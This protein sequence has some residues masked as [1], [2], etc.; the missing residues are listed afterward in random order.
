[1]PMHHGG[2]CHPWQ[3]ELTE[4]QGFHPSGHLIDTSI[5]LALDE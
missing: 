4:A 1:M 2:N 5:M 3:E